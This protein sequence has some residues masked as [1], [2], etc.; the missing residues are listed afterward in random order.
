MR[1]ITY[2]FREV[3]P[4]GIYVSFS[5]EGTLVS[6]SSLGTDPYNGRALVIDLGSVN[7]AGLAL[8]AMDRGLR[9]MQ[10][11]FV[12]R[13][14]DEFALVTLSAVDFSLTDFQDEG[15]TAATVLWLAEEFD[16]PAP[17]IEVHF[18]KALGKYCFEFR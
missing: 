2:K 4:W 1:T 18:S 17:R 9:L 15:I 11:K 5:A 3:A 14:P 16:L 10:D 13:H 12:I 6:K 7:L 8:D